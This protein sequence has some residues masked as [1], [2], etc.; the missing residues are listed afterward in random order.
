VRK[1]NDASNKIF[2]STNTGYLYKEQW[3]AQE[4]DPQL[5]E[6]VEIVQDKSLESVLIIVDKLSG[7][8]EL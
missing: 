8:V 3:E 1:G 2:S 5:K 4:Q 7:V 6:V